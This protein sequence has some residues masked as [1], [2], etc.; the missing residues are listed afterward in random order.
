MGARSRGA[1]PAWLPGVSAV[2]GS[3]VTWLIRRAQGRLATCCVRARAP[4]TG[5]RTPETE[6]NLL[7]WRRAIP[8]LAMAA[9]CRSYETNHGVILSVCG[10]LYPMGR[11]GTRGVISAP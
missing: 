4:G 9:K 8:A 1:R 5:G 6:R 7:R 2:P 10:V 3:G 11:G